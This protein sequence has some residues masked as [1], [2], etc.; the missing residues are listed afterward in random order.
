MSSRHLSIK[1]KKKGER[2]AV[3]DCK[4]EPL[5]LLLPGDAPILVPKHKTWPGQKKKE[6]IRVEIPLHA[7]DYYDAE[8]EDELEERPAAEVKCKKLTHAAKAKPETKK[9]E[10]E[11]KKK[12]RKGQEACKEDIKKRTKAEVEENK[13]KKLTQEIKENKA[14]IM[15]LEARYEALKAG[16]KARN[17]TKINNE[18]DS[19]TRKAITTS[20]DAVQTSDGETSSIELSD[21]SKKVRDMLMRLR[22]KAAGTDDQNK[23]TPSEDAQILARKEAGESFKTIAGYMKRSK[24]Q[25]SQR[26]GELV[27]AGKTVETVAADG[28]GEGTIATDTATA[29]ETT[30]AATTDGENNAQVAEGDFGGLF[31][32]GGLKTALEAVA[33]EQADTENKN[34]EPEKENS[35]KKKDSPAKNS[36]KSSKKSK[37]QPNKSSPADIPKGNKETHPKISTPAGV[38]GGSGYDSGSEAIPDNV[39]TLL[40]N[41]QYARHLLRNK[42]K[43]PE[44]D[45]MFDED[46]CVLL[47]LAESHHK[48]GRWE[49][50]QARFAN[51]TG[52]MVPIDVLKYKLGEGEKPEGYSRLR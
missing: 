7:E 49:Q 17:K 5:N 36:D 25:I 44:A 50:I 33:T 29:G 2:V 30:D 48:H 40:Y 31:D 42:D 15:K 10:E 21:D 14:Y 3:S 22:I 16:S 6:T 52:R 9:E 45:G 35:K 18:T 1:G 43:I 4:L 19:G 46:D 20:D 24:K 28:N 34:K 8:E 27:T 51:F 38:G 26:Y 11:E 13:Y 23:F 41:N 37:N 12:K 39:G 47:A 32:L